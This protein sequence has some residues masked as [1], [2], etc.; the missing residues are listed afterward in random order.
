MHL[1]L[2]NGYHFSMIFL[3]IKKLLLT[4]HDWCTYP[5][6][7]ISARTKSAFG[8]SKLKHSLQRKMKNDSVENAEKC[9]KTQNTFLMH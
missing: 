3:E 5:R 2:L 4:Q 9:T 8:W 6:L 7:R 1:L